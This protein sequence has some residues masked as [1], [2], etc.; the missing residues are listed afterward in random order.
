MKIKIGKVLLCV[1]MKRKKGPKI[2]TKNIRGCV[3]FFYYLH[4]NIQKTVGKDI[5]DNNKFH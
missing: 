2:V 4:P 5:N 1:F 3:F